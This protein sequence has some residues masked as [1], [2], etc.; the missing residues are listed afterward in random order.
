MVMCVAVQEKVLR[1]SEDFAW[2]ANF[3]YYGRFIVEVE[4]L[5]LKI[6]TTNVS[7]L[8]YEALMCLIENILLFY[9]A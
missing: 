6:W 1:T 4:F 8:N 2:S 5:D 7:P 3:A 9:Y